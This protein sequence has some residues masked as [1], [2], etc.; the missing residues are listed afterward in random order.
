MHQP[1]TEPNPFLRPEPRPSPPVLQVGE[2]SL[3]ALGDFLLEDDGP[4]ERVEGASGV[5]G[6]EDEEVGEAA[7]AGGEKVR[8]RKLG[9]IK[10]RG[11]ERGTGEKGGKGRGTHSE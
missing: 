1:H 10:E 7:G 9:G 3:D 6:R 2:P 5:A 11:W 8:G 4:D